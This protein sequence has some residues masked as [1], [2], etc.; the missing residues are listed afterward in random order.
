MCVLLSNIQTAFVYNVIIFLS[1]YHFFS[2]KNSQFAHFNLKSYI[3]NHKYTVPGKWL[4]GKAFLSEPGIRLYPRGRF[5]IYG[6]GTTARKAGSFP[7][8]DPALKAL[9]W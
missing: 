2:H 5:G 3:F 4:E 9:P 7:S 1:T 6:V 8:S